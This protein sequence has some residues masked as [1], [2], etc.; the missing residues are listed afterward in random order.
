MQDLFDADE[1]KFM[2]NALDTHVRAKGL[3]V[4]QVAVVIAMKL[5]GAKLPLEKGGKTSKP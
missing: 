3:S 5:E 1:K 2:I 4:A